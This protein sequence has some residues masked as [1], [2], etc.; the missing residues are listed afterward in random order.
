M[1]NIE[2]TGY[3]IL[4]GPVFSSPVTENTVQVIARQNF[5]ENKNIAALTNLLTAIPVYSYNQFLNLISYMH[6]TLNHEIFDVIDY[7][8]ANRDSIEKEIAITHTENSYMA[9]EQEYTHGTYQYENML[10]SLVRDGETEK[11]S[12]FLLQTVKSIKLQEGKLAVICSDRQ[13]ICL[14]D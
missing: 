7:F 8:D 11:L 2:N 4:V 13:K 5:I 1:I 14:L 3:K 6:Y 10:L 9:K 12:Q